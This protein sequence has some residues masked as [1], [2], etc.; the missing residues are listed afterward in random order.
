MKTGCIALLTGCLLHIGSGASFAD[1]A[2]E[3][4]EHLSAFGSKRASSHDSA[5]AIKPLPLSREAQRHLLAR[6]G[7]GVAPSQLLALQG[8]TRQEAVDHIVQ[9]LRSKPGQ[10]MPA[11]VDQA[12]PHYYRRDSMNEEERQQFNNMRDAELK[13]LRL[14]WIAEMLETSSPQ[15]ERLVFFWHDVFATNYNQ[16]GK[17]SRA[18]ALQNRTFRELGTGSW[19][20]LLKAMIRDPA[21]LDFLDNNTNRRKSPNENL[22]RELLELFTLG[23]GNFDEA[24]VK[25][26]ARALTGMA[27]SDTFDNAYQLRTWHHD[28]GEKTLFGKTARFD[29]DGLVDAI[30]EQPAASRFMVRRFWQAFIADA[31]P[32]EDWVEPMAQRF[33]ESGYDL[34]DLYAA[35]LSSAAFWAPEHRGALIKSPLDIVIGTARALEYPKSRWQSMTMDMG[36]LEMDLFAPPNVAGWPEGPAFIT[37]GRLLSRQYALDA[38]VVTDVAVKPGNSMDMDSDERSAMVSVEQVALDGVSNHKTPSVRVAADLP[39]YRSSSVQLRWANASEK[40]NRQSAMFILDHV[41]TPSK[42]FDLVS[43]NVIAHDD[44]SINMN[45]SSFAC[46]PLCFEQFADCAWEDSLFPAL[47]TVSFPLAQ[48]ASPDTAQE[49]SAFTESDDGIWCGYDDLPA[50]EQAFVAVLW[51]SLPMLFELTRDTKRGLQFAKPVSM[52]ESRLESHGVAVADSFWAQV[53]GENHDQPVE[54]VV[55]SAFIPPLADP[56]RV[57]APSSVVG[58]L[59]ELVAVLATERLSLED[60]LLSGVGSTRFSSLSGLSE[61]SAEQQL[62]RLLD[63]PVFQVR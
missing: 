53:A 60:V 45:I 48:R 63:H 58:S 8:L 38:L 49:N 10:P 33:R 2:S 59:E 40:K 25:A 62:S 29:G 35:V 61:L 50:S 6:S 42:T 3:F 57:A 24:T 52:L 5:D 32:P 4:P 22:A 7:I 11:W 37:P 34:T 30:L 28:S 26:A 14:W 13:Q 12:L 51:R 17:H 16:I 27:S 31:E 21:L 1:S 46:L 43:F 56:V 44:G 20:V 23:E 18:M 54:L 47:K 9:G 15:T 39:A 36:N 41:S 19:E 55:D